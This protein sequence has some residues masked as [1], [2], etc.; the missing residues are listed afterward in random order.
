MTDQQVIEIVE[1]EFRDKT[2]GATEQYLEIHKPI[3]IDNRLKVDRIDRDNKHE[4]TIAYL[5]VS[6]EKFY[7]AIYIDEQ[8]AGI[9]NVGTEPYHRVYFIA[10]SETLSSEELKAMT[11][12]TPTECWN[13]GDLRGDKKRKYTYSGMK[14]LINPEPD[15]FEDK[16]NKLLDF[17][18]Q[19]KVG[20]RKLAQKANGYIQVAMDIHN[21]NTMIGGP[22]LN[23]NTIKRMSNLDL[24]ID[25]DLYTA[26]NYFKS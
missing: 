23:A 25:F 8:T 15:E 1:N 21:G 22:Y 5:P 4:L 20:I 19:D 10:T 12:L 3:Y 11:F 26:G 18:E 13:L 6:N 24:S 2:L 7:F 9:T 16:L 17:L 14:F